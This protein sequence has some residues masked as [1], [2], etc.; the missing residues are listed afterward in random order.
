MRVRRFLFPGR[1]P[2]NQSEAGNVIKVVEDDS[3]QKQAFA[4]LDEL[5]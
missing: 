2:V 4:L 3:V 5:A 1:T